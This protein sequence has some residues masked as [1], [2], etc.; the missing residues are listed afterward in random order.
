[1]QARASISSVRGATAKLLGTEAVAAA[2]PSNLAKAS[3]FGEAANEAQSGHALEFLE[4]QYR[5]C[6]PI[7]LIGAARALLAKA[8]IPETLPSS[9]RRHWNAQPML[10]C[11][12][13]GRNTIHRLETMLPC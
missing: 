7:M 2:F 13:N 12:M 5:H 1:M 8:N 3:E 4:D 6:K 11:A 9:M 10:I